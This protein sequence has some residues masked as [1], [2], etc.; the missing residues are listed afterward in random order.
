M[1]INDRVKSIRTDQGLTQAKFGA[2]IGATRDMVNNV[3]NRRVNASNLY[4]KA[5][6]REFNVSEAWLKTGEGEKYKYLGRETEITRY[7]GDAFG[8]D[9]ALIKRFLIALSCLSTRELE[10]ILKFARELSRD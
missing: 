4:I 10:A 9:D 7:T 5:I 1:T 8:Q 6:C 2:K 3:E